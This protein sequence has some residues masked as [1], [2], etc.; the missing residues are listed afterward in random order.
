MTKNSILAFLDDEIERL[1]KARQL[2]AGFEGQGF[3]GLGRRKGPRNMSA[4]ARAR[5]SAAQ[6]ARWARHRAS[7]K[8]K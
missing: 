4:E 7:Q 2:L 6:K 3:R 5:I 1:R 8:K